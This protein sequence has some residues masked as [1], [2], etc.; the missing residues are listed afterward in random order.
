MPNAPSITITP[1]ET[2]AGFGASVEGVDLNQLDEQTF[3]TLER[4]LY[5]HKL[6]VIRGQAALH[7]SSQLA[8][9]KRFD[10]NSAGVHGH[11]TATQ[12]MEGFKGKKSLV[13]A[14]PAVPCEPMVRMLGRTVVP[15]G[16]FGT[17]EEVTLRSGS[18]VGFHKEPLTEAEML[19]GETRFQRW[20]IDAPFYRTHP[21]KVTSLWSKILPR[22]PDLTARFDDGSGMTMKV[23][24]GLTAFLDTT[25]M[26]ESLSDEDKAW[27]QWSEVEYAPSPYQWIQDAKALGNGF[28]MVSDGLETPF[29]ELPSNDE[30]LVMRYPLLWTNPLD[31]SKAL[32]VH[33]LV[34]RKLFR[35]RSADGPEE[36]IDDVP[37]LRQILYDLQ[38]PFLIPENILVPSAEEG[39]L[40]LWW[41]R[42]L[43]HTA[44]EYPSE[45]YGDRLCHQVHVSSSFSSEPPRPS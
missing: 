7:P 38:R 27:V 28:G 31:G 23:P 13:G 10:P 36:I 29:D 41:N 12:V 26:Y 19:G 35:K 42:G 17:E 32:Q 33:H 1:L 44:M 4:A 43:R 39:D 2:S 20:H 30:S 5:I 11:G 18:H 3:K 34:V 14:N 24:P 37:T 25:R 15:V 9:V 6:L 40:T 22:G 8:L 45:G 16:H 21:P